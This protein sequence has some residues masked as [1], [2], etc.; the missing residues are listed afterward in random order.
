ML[1]LAAA[2][3]FNKDK[4]PVQKPIMNRNH[5]I[6]LALSMILLGLYGG[7]F[8]AGFGVF[9]AITLVLFGYSFLESAAMGR[10]IGFCQSLAAMVIFAQHGLINYPLGVALGIGFAIGSWIGIGITLRKNERYI[11]SLLLL[12]ILL[13]LVKVIL[14]IF[15][16]KF[17]G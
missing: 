16:L 1:L 8:G 7:F 4:L 6:G 5:L 14:N 12:V 17:L 11:K 13:S 15:G 9:I 10:V 2:I 3:L